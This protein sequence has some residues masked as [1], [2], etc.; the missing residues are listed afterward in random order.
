[1]KNDFYTQISK[2]RDKIY[3]L[4]AESRFGFKVTEIGYYTSISLML[5]V[6][7]TEVEV[8]LWNSEDDNR[9]WI[10]EDSDYESFDIYLE[11]KIYDCIEAFKEFKTILK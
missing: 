1:M 3:D 11:R 4:G 5:Y 2:Y 8:S 10:D 9:E 7:D 6:G